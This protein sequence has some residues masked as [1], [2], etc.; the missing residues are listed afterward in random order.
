MQC[1][2]PVKVL[3]PPLLFCKELCVLMCSV[4]VSLWLGNLII[5]FMISVRLATVYIRDQTGSDAVSRDSNAQACR[6]ASDV[7]RPA[8]GILYDIH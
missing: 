5:D 8:L 4:F 6:G 2:D 7:C 3:I 1:L